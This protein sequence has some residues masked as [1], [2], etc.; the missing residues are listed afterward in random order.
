MKSETK[1]TLRVFL[2]IAAIMV[3]IVL[4]APYVFAEPTITPYTVLCPFDGHVASY[5]GKQRI[6]AGVQECSFSHVWIHL[7]PTGDT[8]LDEKHE[9]WEKCEAAKQ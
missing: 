2:I 3:A 6:D 7:D 5:T 9:F 8:T 1:K 4:L